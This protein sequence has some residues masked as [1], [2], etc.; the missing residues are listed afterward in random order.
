[1]CPVRVTGS[2]LWA[3]AEDDARESLQ[4]EEALEAAV[5][6][7][8][9]QFELGFMAGSLASGFGC[10][11]LPPRLW[12]GRRACCRRQNSSL[13]IWRKAGRW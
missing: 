11:W 13:S 3:G 1:M 2:A 12:C 6:K 4:Q 7:A 9:C 8:V 5:R 10:S